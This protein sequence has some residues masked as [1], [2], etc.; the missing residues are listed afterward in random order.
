MPF[1]A[2]LHVTFWVHC[3]AGR[4]AEDDVEWITVAYALGSSVSL[5]MQ[6]LMTAVGMPRDFMLEEALGPGWNW[7]LHRGK[8]SKFVVPMLK[9]K[10]QMLRVSNSR[11][12]PFP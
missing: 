5:E 12:L 2:T 3:H 8:V 1:L 9:V 6:Q 7:T 4:G 10:A 11:E